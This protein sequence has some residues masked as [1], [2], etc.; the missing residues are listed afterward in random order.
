MHTHP[1]F[2]VYLS[3]IDNATYTA[4]R[5]EDPEILTLVYDPRSG[6]LGW[7]PQ[8]DSPPKRVSQRALTLPPLVTEGVIAAHAILGLIGVT[9]I[10]HAGSSPERHLRA[11]RAQTQ[12]ALAN[13]QRDQFHHTMREVRTVES[14]RCIT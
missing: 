5:R 13:I 10:F 6:A 3:P 12:V 7:F 11:V 1:G 4:Y 8:P 14:R 2:G 9:H